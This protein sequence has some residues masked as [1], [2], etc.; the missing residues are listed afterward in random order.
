MYYIFFSSSRET[1]KNKWNY[2]FSILYQFNERHI[3]TN[4]EYN[5]HIWVARD[6]YF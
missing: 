3:A 6:F 2:V 5:L 1:I 4:N